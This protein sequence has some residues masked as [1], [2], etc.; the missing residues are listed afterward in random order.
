MTA[1]VQKTYLDLDF[2]ITQT[3]ALLKLVSDQSTAYHN[4]IA[5]AMDEPT[6]DYGKSGKD[7]VTYAY[8]LVAG[9]RKNEELAK[10]LRRAIYDAGHTPQS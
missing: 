3:Q 8:E 2:T 9:L 1:P 5:S 7:N 6:A 4:W 10:K